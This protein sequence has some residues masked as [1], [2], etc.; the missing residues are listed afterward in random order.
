MVTCFSDVHVCVQ[1]HNS[2]K[3]TVRVDFLVPRLGE[4]G[5]L[6]T[7]GVIWNAVL[8]QDK[9]HYPWIGTNTCNSILGIRIRFP[10]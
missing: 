2:G 6:E 10:I 9:S 4:V 5:K 1:V 7:D 8:F 3:A